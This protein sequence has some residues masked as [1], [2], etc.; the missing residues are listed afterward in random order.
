MLKPDFLRKKFDAGLTYQDY[1][2]TGREHHRAGWD[3]LHAQT[4]L[5]PDQQDLIASFVRELN[6]LIVSGIWCGDCAQQMPI[7]DHIERA[8]PVKI[9]C[10]F[11]DRDAHM[12]LAE[13]VMLCGGLRVPVVLILN[14]DFDLLSLAGDRTLARYRAMAKNLLGPACSLP[15]AP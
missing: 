3:R 5:D 12:D 4:K 8:N 13:R 1:L 9:R 2:T 7:L 14:E 15:G 11:L 6:V 10:R